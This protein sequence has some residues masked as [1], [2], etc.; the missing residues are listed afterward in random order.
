LSPRT[1]ADYFSTCQRLVAG[2]GRDRLVIDLAA[3]DFE[4]LRAYLTKTMGP[5][6][7]ANEINRVRVLFKYGYEAGLIERPVRYGP[8]FKRPSRRVLRQARHDKGP[9]LFEASE[10]RA[11]LDKA[12][13]PLRAMV[14]LGINCGFGNGDVANLQFS[15][16]DLDKGWAN[17]PRPKTAIERR[18]PLWRETIEAIQEATAARKEPK[19]AADKDAVF[20][21]RCRT[22]WVKVR[23]K[24]EEDE[25][26]NENQE[27]MIVDDAVSKAFTKVLKQLKLHRPGL[28]FYSLRHT[29]QTIGEGSKDAPAVGSIMGHADA[30]MAAVYRQRIDDSRLVAVVNHVRT[31]L[32][33][34]EVSK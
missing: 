32:F 4:A 31:W 24:V 19:D 25:D 5:N 16:L 3:D 15:N 9:R 18:C 11:I 1:W 14:L 34:S 29:F 8:A 22:R 7:L 21:T 28:G 27:G 13:Q 10:L 26:G 33:G 17:F 30:S 23:P 12:E 2:F 6:T 20:L